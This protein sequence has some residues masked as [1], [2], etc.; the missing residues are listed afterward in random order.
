[1]GLAE[2]FKDAT[3]YGR[4]VQRAL[5]AVKGMTVAVGFGSETYPDG[6]SVADVALYHEYGT[7]TM[8]A[9]PFLTSTGKKNQAEISRL[10]KDVGAGACRGTDPEEP[11]KKLAEKLEKMY[12]EEI[13]SGNYAANAPSTIARKGSSTPLVD[14]GLMSSAVHA[15]VKKR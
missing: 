9:R 1:M 14:T 7:S 3:P 5:E 2:F 8:P 13:Q 12:R 10:V 11:A 4:K 6:T 15:Q